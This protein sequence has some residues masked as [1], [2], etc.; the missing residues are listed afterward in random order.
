MVRRL[1]GVLVDVALMCRIR[2][3]FVVAIKPRLEFSF[4]CVFFFLNDG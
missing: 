3:F 2:L 4:T 1:R